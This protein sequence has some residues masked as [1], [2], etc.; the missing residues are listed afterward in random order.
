MTN[1]STQF[2]PGN[3]IGA[4]GR[5]KGARNKFG[6]DFFI[7]LQKDFHQHGAQVIAEVRKEKPEAYLKTAASLVPRELTLE[8]SDDLKEFLL[9]I[10]A[11][12]IDQG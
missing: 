8:A 10:E 9:Q 6:E 5:P 7:A 3:K 11:N 1:K 4:K 2:K 12:L